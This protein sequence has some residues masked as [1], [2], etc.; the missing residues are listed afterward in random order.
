M[1]FVNQKQKAPAFYKNRPSDIDQSLLTVI[2]EAPRVA[3][4]SYPK[5]WDWRILEAEQ[6]ISK[7]MKKASSADIDSS[8]GSAEST[9]KSLS[10]SMEQVI[11]HDH[12]FITI[13][14]RIFMHLWEI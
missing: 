8:F 13:R 2:P 5:H 3:G 10:R 7:G 14:L 12:I 1:K 11:A 4:S 6:A 9:T